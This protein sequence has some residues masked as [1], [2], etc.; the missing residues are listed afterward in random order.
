MSAERTYGALRCSENARQGA[1]PMRPALRLLYCLLL[2]P[3]LLASAHPLYGQEADSLAADTLQVPGQSFPGQ[4]LPTDTLRAAQGDTLAADSL[5]RAR[6]DSLAAIPAVGFARAD[7]GRALTQQLPARLPALELPELLAGE[8]GSFLYDFGSAGWPDGWAWN[9]LAPHRAGLAF[10]AGELTDLYTGRPRFELLPLMLTDPPR[11]DAHHLGRPVAV[12]AALRDYYS[13]E[14]LS[15]LRY[16]TDSDG[17]QSVAGLHVQQRQVSPF[18]PP[19]LLQVL[20]AYGGRSAAGDYP[21]G[22]LGGSQLRGMRQIIGRIRYLQRTWSLEITEFYNRRH[23]GAYSG[24]EPV[25]GNF[26]T[27]YIPVGAQLRNPNAWRQTIRNDLSMTLRLRAFGGWQPASM[28]GYWTTAMFRYTRPD[29]AAPNDSLTVSGDRL[30][31]RL[32]QPFALAGHD[33]RLMLHGT[34]QWADRVGDFETPADTATSANGGSITRLHA[35]LRDSA[36]LAGADLHLEGALHAADDLPLVTGRA[37]LSRSMGTIRLFASAQ[38]SGQPLPFAARSGFGEWLVGAARA[39]KGRASTARIGLSLGAG[40]FDVTAY[41]F[42]Q[43]LTDALDYVSEAPG[44]TAPA[45]T[46]PNDTARAVLADAPIRRIGAAATI[47]WR[48]QARRGFYLTA[49][50]TYAALLGGSDASGPAD[51]HERIAASLP[52]FYMTGRF[53]ARTLLFQ[54]DLDL[55]MYLRGRFWTAFRSRA[56]HPPTGLLILPEATSRTFGPSG[57]VD[58]VVEAGI[59]TATLFFSVENILSDSGRRLLMPGTLL[60]PTYPLS[61]WRVRFGVYWPIMN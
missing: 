36:R 25:G 9:G 20:A 53:G 34:L 28:S 6:T 50:P 40:S 12:R 58:F 29:A 41:G 32:E 49:R 44:G 22:E 11:L 59:R 26:E 31:L 27:I 42:A 15:E 7:A 57:T 45:E 30:G 43:H 19:G 23:I 8:S 5:R 35:S 17:L 56:L 46:A 54:G 52:A 1:A 51:L 24:V 16:W 39:P 47:G 38:S 21:R 14:P 60:V 37:S 48:R 33:L 4:V 2:A 10:G 61:S 3:L 13:P 18:G 55:D